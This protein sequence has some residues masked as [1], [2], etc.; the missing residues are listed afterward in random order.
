MKMTL[1][2][3]FIMSLFWN[4]L[5]VQTSP[6]LNSKPK[7][8][9]TGDF[10]GCI[11]FSSQTSSTPIFWLFKQKSSNK[12]EFV[13]WRKRSLHHQNIGTFL[14]ISYQPPYIQ[15]S[16]IGFLQ[17]FDMPVF[18]KVRKQSHKFLNS[19]D[20]GPVVIRR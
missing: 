10:F 16:L 14:S 7:Q 13:D 5:S 8:M 2:T 3:L 15:K 4:A 12:T 1:T 20:S 11:L 17:S 19:G 6:N 18:P 9:K